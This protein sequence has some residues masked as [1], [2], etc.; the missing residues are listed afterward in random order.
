L[1]LCALTFGAC[2]PAVSPDAEADQGLQ[3]AKEGRLTESLEAF[4]AALSA[5]P[6]HPKA[7][8]NEGMALLGLQRWEE[9]AV[10]F[11]RFVEARP[12]DTAGWFEKARAET[13]A[14]Q[15]EQGLLSL[16]RAVSLGFSDYELL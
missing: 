10:S 5:E 1:L 4:R 13:L 12:D 3:L 14:G 16:Q 6:N 9:A 8:F 15:R 11:T 7:R 2:A